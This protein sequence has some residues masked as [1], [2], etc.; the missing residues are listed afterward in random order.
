M[1]KRLVVVP[2]TSKG[3][4]TATAIP[5]H[6]GDYVE[7]QTSITFDQLV[8][9]C[10]YSQSL[11]EED[12]R[13]LLEGMTPEERYEYLV[14]DVGYYTI[15]ELAVVNAADI[16]LFTKWSNKALD[17]ETD[18]T[19]YQACEDYNEKVRLKSI[20]VIDLFNTDIIA[21]V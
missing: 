18:S 5:F 6:I 3:S 8:T 10:A 11:K 9:L 16:T 13:P 15:D 14:E 1:K 12:V 21:L 20:K 2:L 7:G 4:E 19:L 17:H